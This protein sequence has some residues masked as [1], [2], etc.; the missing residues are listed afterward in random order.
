MMSITSSSLFVCLSMGAAITA[1]HFIVV[2]HPNGNNQSQRLLD[3]TFS[4]SKFLNDTN[5]LFL[6]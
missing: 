1:V 2:F 6:M 5:L 4:G 3:F